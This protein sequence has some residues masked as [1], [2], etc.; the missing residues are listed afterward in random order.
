MDMKIKCKID[1]HVC[2]LPDS[3]VD[4]FINTMLIYC[5]TL[6]PKLKPHIHPVIFSNETN[7]C[8]LTFLINK[9]SRMAKNLSLNPK[10]SLAIDITHPINPF[11]NRGIMIKASSQLAESNEAVQT[12]VSQL[13]GKYGLSN[14]AKIIGLDTI[15]QFVRVCVQPFKIVYWKGPYFKQFE[16]TSRHKKKN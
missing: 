7:C 3:M 9:K 15:S 11:W 12:C 10:I 13:Q 1:G 6:S 4:F 14:I 5:S 16:C 2:E 8:N